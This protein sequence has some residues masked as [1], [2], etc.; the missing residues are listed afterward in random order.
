M[1][2]KQLEVEIGEVL[3]VFNLIPGNKKAAH[4]GSPVSF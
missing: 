2:S 1:S 3:I 4:L